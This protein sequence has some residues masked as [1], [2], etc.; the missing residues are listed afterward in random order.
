MGYGFPAALGAQAAYPDRPVIAIVGDG[1]FQ[2]NIQELATAAQYNL[3]V[4]VFIVNNQNLGMVRQ[5]QEIYYQKRYSHVDLSCSPDFVKVAE[6]YGVK[7]FRATKPSELD[8]MVDAAM[9]HDGPVVMD[10]MVTRE[11]NVFPMV[12]PGSANRNMLLSFEKKEEIPV[13]PAGA[14]INS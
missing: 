14:A 9:K 4:K 3:P 13:I 5:W 2:M 1:G 7:G 12:G 11:E 8:E 10:C 6:A